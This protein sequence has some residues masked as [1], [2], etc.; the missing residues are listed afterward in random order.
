M[1]I[2]VQRSVDIRRGAWYRWDMGTGGTVLHIGASDVG[3][4]LFSGTMD[5]V[6]FFDSALTA[7]QIAL[8][9]REPYFALYPEPVPFYSIPAAAPGG[10]AIPGFFG[11]TLKPVLPLFKDVNL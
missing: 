4:N 9:S 6:E 5:L 7:D 1:S 11:S 10:L 2:R 3:G 8:R